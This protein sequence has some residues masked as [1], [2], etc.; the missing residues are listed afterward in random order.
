M[1]KRFQKTLRCPT[2]GSAL[3]L[4]SLAETH[5]NLEDDHRARAIEHGLLDDEF[6]IYVETGLLSCHD[7]R[8]WFPI[9]AGLPVLL[10][11]TTPLH[12][13]FARDNEKGLAQLGHRYTF[14]SLNPVPGERFVLR[15]FS[16]EWLEYDF[17][18]V[19]WEMDYADHE[20]RFLTELGPYAPANSDDLFLELGCGLGIT[21]FLAQKNF[22][23]D[24]VGV[25]LSFAAMKAA[26][27][28]RGNPF[29][30]FVEA[31]VFHLPFAPETFGAVYS[32]GVLHH[33]YSTHEAFRALARSCRPGGSM[34]L[35]VYGPKSI[36]D[37]LFRRCTY[38]VEV[39]MRRLLSR[40]SHGAAQEAALAPFALAYAAFNRVRRW[41]DPTIQPYNYRRALH[42][43]RDRFTPEFAHRQDD[44]QVSGWFREAGFEQIEV[45]D[46]RQ[47]PTADHDD[48]RR[49]TGV[50]GRLPSS[51]LAMKF[52]PLRPATSVESI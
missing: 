12:V 29:L 8:V 46:W 15:S 24:A 17:D 5:A 2:C 43:A 37:N 11:Y 36:D 48:Y 32:R 7:C 35:W 47:M 19:I 50:R 33:T 10:P 9:E 38:G 26:Q 44:H 4:S 30:H 3:E 14:P 28:Y 49:N 6:A 16:T 31:S 52:R 42:A 22:G 34:Y 45:V 25:D 21:T 1:W 20:K 18:G 27:H 23:V 41:A 13:R 39:A 40:G 51:D